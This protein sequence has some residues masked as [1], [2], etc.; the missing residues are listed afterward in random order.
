MAPLTANALWA[1][2]DCLY[3]GA[4]GTTMVGQGAMLEVIDAAIKNV[5]TRS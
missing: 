1:A 3:S 4:T 5:G 2:A